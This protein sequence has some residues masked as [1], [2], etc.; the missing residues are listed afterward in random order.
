MNLLTLV[1]ALP[2]SA[3][4]LAAVANLFPYL[5][6]LLTRNPG[7]YTGAITLLLSAAGGLLTQWAQHGAEHFDWKKAAGE[8]AGAYLIALVH[9]IGLLRNTATAD[10]LHRKGPQLGD[11]RDDDKLLPV[12]AA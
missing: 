10:N 11:P 8:A 5:S 2:T 7:W 1:D 9:Q 12:T 3:I 4:V 6:A